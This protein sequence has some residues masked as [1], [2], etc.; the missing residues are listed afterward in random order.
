[1]EDNDDE[2]DDGLAKNEEEEEEEEE[3]IEKGD[4]SNMLVLRRVLHVQNSPHDDQQLNIF[5]IRCTINAKV[6]S[7]IV[8]S[9][10]YAN[11]ASTTLMEKLELPSS[12]HPY[13]YQL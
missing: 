8:N 13:L 5:Q 12:P 3:V 10:S 6:C 4:G 9:G 7:I 2:K 1:M 11:V